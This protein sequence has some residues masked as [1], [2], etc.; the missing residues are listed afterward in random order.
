MDLAFRP[1]RVLFLVGSLQCLMQRLLHEFLHLSKLL[2]TLILKSLSKECNITVSLH[3]DLHS[4]DDGGCPLDDQIFQSIL[5]SEVGVNKLLHCLDRH[6]SLLALL[7]VLEFGNKDLLDDL[8][9]L[10]Q[11]N[12]LL[13]LACL[14]LIRYVPDRPSRS[15]PNDLAHIGVGGNRRDPY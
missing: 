1:H 4:I 15:I 11:G 5:L 13:V 7:V 6:L 12:N 10:L 8:F 3:V 9:Q 2:I 14:A